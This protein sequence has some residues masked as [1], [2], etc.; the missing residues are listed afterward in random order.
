MKSIIICEGKTDLI[1][2]SYYLGKVADWH[3]LH[4]SE[5][6]KYKDRP[7]KFS[8]DNPSNQSFEWY[9]NSKSDLLCIYAVGSIDKIKD[10][11]N[12]VVEINLLSNSE[13]F[14]NIVIVCD[15]DD[16]KIESSIFGDIHIAT[17]GHMT[18]ESELQNNTW[19]NLS[20]ELSG[21][22]LTT[23]LIPIIIPFDVI[24]TLETFLLN[25]RREIDDCESELICKCESFMESLESAEAI[26]KRYITSRGIKPKI[27]LGTYFSVVSPNRTFDVGNEIL[28]SINWE[29]YS[30]FNKTFEC[31]VDL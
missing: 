18:L 21:D 10:G 23:K 29:E 2:L 14:D 9:A 28:T 4:G 22:T 17:D 27:L 5:A 8:I 31:L 12:Q 25:C 11:L 13:P 24:G 16:D 7:L 26:Q 19:V 3:H 1:L 6:K 20:Y 15:R 30:K